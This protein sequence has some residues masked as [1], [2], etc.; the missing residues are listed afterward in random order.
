MK[1]VFS[2]L[3]GT[4]LEERSY[5]FFYAK[6]A[7]RL[8]KKLG[9]PVVLVTSKTMGEVLHWQK[10]L[11]IDGPF[12][13]ENGAAIFIPKDYFHFKIPM[14]KEENGWLIIWLSEGISSIKKFVEKMRKD[15]F[16]IEALTEMTVNRAA[17]LTGLSV[18]LAREAKK[19]D[20]DEC[21]LLHRGNIADFKIRAGKSGISVVEGGGFYHLCAGHDKGKAVKILLEFFE[22]KFG[23]VESTGIGDSEN[24]FPMLDAVDFGYLVRK[25]D[26]SYAS[27]KFEKANAKN[28]KGWA[29]II[30]SIF[31]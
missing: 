25:A 8:L 14:A 28:S 3:D 21:I 18:S 17:K 16:E 1:L 27:K 20:F 23:A 24:D 29:E 30:S 9:V 31:S 10:K 5:S 19:R 11:G 15:G 22:K 4:L 2:D 6:P 26:G 7:L 12:I 13:C